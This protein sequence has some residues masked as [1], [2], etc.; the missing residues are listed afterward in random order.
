[1]ARNFIVT[2]LDASNKIRIGVWE[3]RKFVYFNQIFRLTDYQC[4]NANR[5][6]H[7][8]KQLKESSSSL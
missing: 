7:L 8:R 4:A 5:E 1:M 6:N 3:M 2:V